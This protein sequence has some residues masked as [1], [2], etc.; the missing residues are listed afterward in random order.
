MKA[1][2]LVT[3][4][5][6][7]MLL[8]GCITIETG[9]KKQETKQEES[10]KVEKESKTEDNLSVAKGEE[11]NSSSLSSQPS[12]SPSSS[13]TSS[14]AKISGAEV[15]KYKEDIVENANKIGDVIK[16][17]ENSASSDI[18][19][20]S[21]KKSEIQLSSGGAQAYARKIKYLKPPTELQ[22]EHEKIAQSMDLY[23]EAFQLLSE[24]VEE[25]N[26]SKLRQSMGKSH[27]GAKVFEEATIGI[28]SKTN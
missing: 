10:K 23:Y 7:V 17:I 14:T 22:A 4:A 21:L 9:G 1:K 25:Q 11:S 24:A 6:P 16:L 8:S 28:E 15:D 3:L 27:Q 26:E 12:S 5:I 13:S 2:K 20:Y 18:K 19:E